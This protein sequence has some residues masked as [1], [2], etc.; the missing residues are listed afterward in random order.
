MTYEQ[1]IFTICPCYEEGLTQNEIGEKQA[2]NECGKY[3]KAGR[4]NRCV[5]YR[6]G[7]CGHC[8]HF[9]PESQEATFKWPT[10]K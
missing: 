8:N 5:H 10:K 4:A 2:Q 3:A 7:T 6:H 9:R 1:K